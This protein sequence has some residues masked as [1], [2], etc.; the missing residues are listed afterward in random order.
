MAVYIAKTSLATPKGTLSD[1]L[2]NIPSVLWEPMER[3]DLR[4]WELLPE[5]IEL[6]QLELPAGRHIL[7]LTVCREDDGSCCGS[8]VG[9]SCR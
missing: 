1:L 7:R 4:Q 2:F 6:A 8:C 3:A 5:T 9:W